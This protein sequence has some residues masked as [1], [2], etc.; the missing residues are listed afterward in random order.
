MRSW[1][2]GTCVLLS[3]LALIVDAGFRAGIDDP[4]MLLNKEQKERSQR[5]SVHL[6]VHLHFINRTQAE[7]KCAPASACKE[8]LILPVW[9]PVVS[10]DAFEKCLSINSPNFRKASLRSQRLT[11]QLFTL[12]LCS[13]FSWASLLW[14]TGKFN[15][16]SNNQLLIFKVY[17]GNWSNHVT[18][19]RSQSKKAEWRENRG[20][21]ENLERNRQQFDPHGFGIVSARN[22][23]VSDWNLRKQIWRQAIWF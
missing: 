1:L 13:T 17:G 8:G 16:V 10:W 9:E 3:T 22:S 6:P 18:G 21:G 2:L 14:P 7:D 12:L 19:K 15:A 11:E 23:S 20:L 5:S 4:Q